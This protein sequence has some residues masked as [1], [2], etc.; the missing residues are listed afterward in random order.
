M[1]HSGTP[2]RFPSTA[3]L[4]VDSVDRSSG[5]SSD[6][7]ITKQQN[8][9][10]G[11]FTRLGVVEIV[12]DWCKYNISSQIGNN[13]LTITL[14][15]SEVYTVTLI[16]DGSYTVAGV[17]DA[18]AALLNEAVALNPP[19]GG[20]NFI[21]TNTPLGIIGGGEQ[22]LACLNDVGDTPVDF[23]VQ[24]G[25]LQTQLDL[26]LNGGVATS[27]NPITCPNLLRYKY[28]DIVCSNITYQQGLKDAST[29]NA[30]R[31]V[32]YRWN[33]AWDT[34]APVDT[35]G[36]PIFQGYQRFMA[37][38]YLSFPKQVKWNA[39]Q[40]IGQLSFQVYTDD[41]QLLTSSNGEFEYQM[42]LLVSE[43]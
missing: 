33:F 31:D 22:Y 41:G 1:D 32:L 39:D 10:A 30:T 35:Y 28:M 2:I 20:A 42:T 25:K 21:I 26:Q 40:P 27:A 15:S 13:T 6:F 12:V 34:P 43:Q 29:S 17:L 3:N 19:A 5:S 37:R 7:T 36:Y 4:Y 18:I 11:F 23:T 9:L 16:A 14:A 8:I 24:A 38:R